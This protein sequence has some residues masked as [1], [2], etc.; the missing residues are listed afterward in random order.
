MTKRELADVKMKREEARKRLRLKQQQQIQSLKVSGCL[1]V[2]AQ[3]F[4]PTD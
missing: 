4:T 1:R 2:P 3:R